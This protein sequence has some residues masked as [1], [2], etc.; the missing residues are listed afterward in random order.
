MQL[1]G[2]ACVHVG[3]RAC[4]SQHGQKRH[5]DHRL[6]RVAGLPPPAPRGEHPRDHPLLEAL[7]GEPRLPG[8]E[9]GLFFPHPEGPVR[10]ASAPILLGVP[11]LPPLPQQGCS[12]LCQ[13][14]RCSLRLPRASQPKR[15]RPFPKHRFP[16]P[17]RVPSCR[18]RCCPV[19]RVHP[20]C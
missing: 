4:V 16:L 3:D 2:G 14:S 12:L 1:T 9:G 5:D 7:H 15:P 6:E 10:P 13:P 8:P 11:G 20:S 17:E 18:P 19:F